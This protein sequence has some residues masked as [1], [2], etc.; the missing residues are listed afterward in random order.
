MSP[1]RTASIARS[2][3]A[4]MLRNHCS[5]S[6]GST[7][8]SHREHTPTA[9]VCGSIF[10]S[11]PADFEVLDDLLARFLARQ[12]AIRAAVLV[13]V[14]GAV[15]NRDLLEAVTLAQL[16]VDRVVRGRDFQRAGA[17]FAI[18]RRVGDDLYLAP[19]QR[20]PNSLAD[21]RLVAL[22][23]GIHRDG[24]VA[25]HRLGPRRRDRDRAG[26][27][28]ERVADVP[29]AARARPCDR[30]RD[31]TAPSRIAGTS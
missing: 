16:E 27:V 20:Q 8:V 22:V 1:L 23:V 18:D 11:S 10:S 31:R 17:E 26:A 30:L 12:P 6:I 3:I 9:C 29:E 13:D 28:G 7:T 4:R 25:E 24:G 21:V 14:R 15:E 19:D 5:E 2:A